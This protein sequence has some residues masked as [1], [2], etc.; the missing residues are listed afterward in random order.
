MIHISEN[1]HVLVKICTYFVFHFQILSQIFSNLEIKDLKSCSQVNSIWDET[2]SKI[3]K[4]RG[5]VHLTTETNPRFGEVNIFKYLSRA[6]RGMESEV[7][8]SVPNL[9]NP[10]LPGPDVDT[11]LDAFKQL[12]SLIKELSITWGVN[13]EDDA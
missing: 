10:K 13:R 5:V 3:L 6:W 9:T 11:L 1:M 8:I 4:K 2:A 12:A 7:K